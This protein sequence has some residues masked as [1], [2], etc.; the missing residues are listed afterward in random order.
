MATQRM[1]CGE[2]PI[3]LPLVASSVWA[4]H[5]TQSQHR[6]PWRTR[7][8]PRHVGDLL[9]GVEAGDDGGLPGKQYTLR[10]DHGACS[11]TFGG[12]CVYIPPGQAI[13]Y[14]VQLPVQKSVTQAG[15]L[16][17]EAGRISWRIEL[18]Q[19]ERNRAT[20]RHAYTHTCVFHTC[21]NLTSTARFNA[22][23]PTHIRDLRVCGGA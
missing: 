2:L 11:V 8:S 9:K 22:Q 13:K 16:V 14:E 20:Y 3:L 17:H 12:M 21:K 1:T 6:R 19:R 5:T 18:S 15:Y 23:A 7:L 10:L 4:L